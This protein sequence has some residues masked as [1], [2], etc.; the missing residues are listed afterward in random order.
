[1]I[2]QLEPVTGERLSQES[3]IRVG[4]AGGP[5]DPELKAKIQSPINFFSHM[6]EQWAWR[7][8]LNYSMDIKLTGYRLDHVIC[9]DSGIAFGQALAQAYKRLADSSEGA[10]GAGMAFGLIDEAAARVGISFENRAG[11][12]IDRGTVALS[13]HA[14]D[15]NSADLIAFLAG[16]AQGG[17][18]TIQVSLLSGEDPHHIWE[19]VF[20]GLGE[21]TRT[22]FSPCPWRSGTTPG[23]AGKIVSKT[24]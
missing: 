13:E 4:I 18:L 16:L 10:N 14:E 12:V 22:A 2:F 9:E 23:V 5:R 24:E 6:I 21:A 20:R 8:C 17:P 1:M 3:E 7:S 15:A 11:F 19:A